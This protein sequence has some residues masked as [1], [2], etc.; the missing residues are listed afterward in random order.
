MSIEPNQVQIY[1]DSAD[2]FMVVINQDELVIDVNK[3]GCKILGYA[4]EEA[5][6]KNWFDNFVPKTAR[7][8]SKMVFHEMLKG[9]LS[10]VHSEYPIMTKGGKQVIINWHN[11]LAKNEMG[12]T[13]GVLSSGVDVTN[14]RKAEKTSKISENRL[15]NTLDSMLEGCQIIDF[16]FRY[17]YLNDSAAK[18]ARRSKED[19]L[20]HSMM[21]MFPGID[22]TKMFSHLAYCLTSRVPYKMENEF[23]YP[24]GAKGWFEL[25]IEPVPEGVLVFSIDITKRKETEAELGRYRQRLEDVLAERASEF[26]KMNQKLTQEIDERRKSEEGLVLRAIILD[27]AREAIFLV[28]KNGDFVY[29][30]EAATKNYGYSRDEFLNMNIRQLLRPQEAPMIETRF[31]NV[32]EA[33]QLELE[34]VHIRKDKSTIPVQVH[35]S[36]VKTL[37]GE[38]IVSVVRDLENVRIR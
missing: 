30:N 19:L 21:E 20:G 18:Q 15:Q 32:I 3:V 17:V 5:A 12:R 33:G 1:F 11:V 8:N 36:L 7:E 14:L 35:H 26:A 6:G 29:S 13:V 27:N 4:K 2:V 25:R 31:K 9:A 37:H 34:T 16:D 28:N 23:T 10:H 24:D 22:Q 38:F